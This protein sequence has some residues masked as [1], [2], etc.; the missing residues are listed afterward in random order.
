VQFKITGRAIAGA[1]AVVA[2]FVGMSLLAHAYQHEL[3]ALVRGGGVWGM[4][5]FIAL[6]AVFVVFLI[7]L[8]IPLLIPIAVTIWGPFATAVMSIAGWTMGSS[9]AFFSARHF[10]TPLVAQVAGKQELKQ[11]RKI[12]K[13]V[14][15]KHHLF[16]WVIGAQ[17]LLPSDLT[18]Y[19]FGLFADDIDLG[20]Y[21]LAT[22]IGDLLPGFFFAF[23]GTLPAWYQIAALAAA[24]VVAGVLFWRSREA[25]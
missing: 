12:A 11:A 4:A 6:T 13:R 10:G 20:P 9:I 8:D 7:P 24:C 3:G 1:L 14:I 17:A 19:A 16:F 5:G 23:A 18:S 15:P 2:G 25:D 22:A 21:A